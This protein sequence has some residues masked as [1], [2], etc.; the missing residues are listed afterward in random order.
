MRNAELTPRFIILLP[1]LD[2]WPSLARLLL[3]I[4]K[5]YTI[6]DARFDVV[7][8][9]DG[10]ISE[11]REISELVLPPRSCIRSVSIIRLALNFGHQ[12]AIAA[13]LVSMSERANVDGIIIMDSDGEDR[14][15]DIGALMR[16]WRAR[17][18]RIAVAH[19][20][21]RSENRIFRTGYSLYK[22]F[23]W[24]LVGRII[25]FG[26]FCLLPMAA[27]R[28][29]VRMPELWSNLPAAIVRSR[30]PYD[31]VDTIRGERYFGSSRMNITGLVSHGLSAMSIYTDVI[32]VRVLI[33][34]TAVCGLSV[35]AAL[36]VTII[37]FATPLA[38]PGWATTI[39]GD[40]LIIVIQTLVLLIATTLMILTNRTIR[41]FYPLMDAPRFVTS[42]DTIIP[43]LNPPENKEIS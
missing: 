39:V 31:L 10:S 32:F 25:S 21:K 35:L 22:M 16:S 15:D 27:A 7:A 30:L 28:R 17:A 12:R 5:T 19:R 2:D 43:G 14:P 4:D 26:N 41:Q 36:A 20:A 24:I 23:F 29:L 9:D 37:R 34:S 3:D 13:G 38:V 1:V 40:L 8:V 18:N 6:D 33:A 11:S 42:Y